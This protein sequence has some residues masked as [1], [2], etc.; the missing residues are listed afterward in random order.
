MRALSST[1]RALLDLM[2][3]GVTPTYRPKPQ[4][5]IQLPNEHDDEWRRNHG[6]K[7]VQ[8]HILK[9]LESRDWHLQKTVAENVG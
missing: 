6:G 5:R 8:M 3:Q 7:P 1:Q 4:S 2:R 9:A